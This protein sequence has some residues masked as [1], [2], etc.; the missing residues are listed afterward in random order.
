MRIQDL[1]QAGLIKGQPGSLLRQIGGMLACEQSNQRGAN[2]IQ[3]RGRDR[4]PA[5]LLRGHI[6]IGSHHSVGGS[7]LK[8]GHLYSPK[9]DQIDLLRLHLIEDIAG[10]DIAVNDGGMQRL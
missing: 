3:I 4:P 7:R 5:K 9:I 1:A 8:N 6:A 10:L 2:P